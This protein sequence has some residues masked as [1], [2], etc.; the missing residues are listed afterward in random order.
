MKF[1]SQLLA[2][3]SGSTGGCTYSHNRYGLYIRNRSIPVNTNT[4]FQQAVRANFAAL[5]TAWASTLTQ[6]Q[7]D[8]WNAYAAI[9]PRNDAQG[10]PQFVT[11]AN[12]YIA[13]NAV[14]MAA[15]LVR[16]DTAPIILSMATLTPPTFTLVASTGVATV[17]FTNTDIW[18]TATLGKLLA[19]SSRGQPASRSFFKGP[20]RYRG[21]ISGAVTPPTS[22][23]TINVGS[24]FA[25]AVGQRVFIRFV[26]TNADVRM[27]TPVI[28]SAI[29][30]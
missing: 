11:G 12:W 20:F 6:A 22:P 3:A 17:A 21:L 1:T 28:A 30:S 14:R 25:V 7:R 15:A 18:A 2:T 4:T 23:Q 16:T 13:L 5:T 26:G 27:S 24:S 19:F 9:V 29:A 8:G 10:A